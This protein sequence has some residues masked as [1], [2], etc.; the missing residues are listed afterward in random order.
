M[1]DVDLLF[2]YGTL[3]SGTNNEFARF[4]FS[5]S[6]VVGRGYFHG[7]LYRVSWYPGAIQTDDPSKKV[8]G[9][10]LRMTSN[11]KKVLAELDD[12]EGISDRYEPPHEYQRKVVDIHLGEKTLK[13]WVYLYTF[14]VDDL[15]HIE[16]G[17]FKED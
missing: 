8:Y 13:S 12:Y 16:S 10:L 5:N 2:V 7:E 9:Q 15:E 1:T 17:K 6:E 14:P 3:Q 4:L 11:P